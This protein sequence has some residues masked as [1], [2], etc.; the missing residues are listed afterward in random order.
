MTS[1]GYEAFACRI[2]FDLP[3]VSVAGVSRDN[4]QV[5][6]EYPWVDNIRHSQRM[7]CYSV[8]LSEG[9]GTHPL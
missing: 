1:R 6:V 5:V 7:D 2:G 8:H 9:P 3:H 4:W